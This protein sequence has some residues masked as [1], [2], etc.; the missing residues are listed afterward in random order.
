MR[1]IWPIKVNSNIKMPL[2][3]FYT[4]R[5][6]VVVWHKREWIKEKTVYLS[7][8]LS[9]VEQRMGTWGCSCVAGQLPC[10]FLTSWEKATALTKR[11]PWQ[12]TNLNFSGCILDDYITQYLLLMLPSVHNVPYSAIFCLF[13]GILAFIIFFKLATFIKH[14]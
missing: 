5:P 14:K 13:K 12:T 2:K 3:Y 9:S 4:L 11:W 7:S 1:W 8:S 6:I 10:T